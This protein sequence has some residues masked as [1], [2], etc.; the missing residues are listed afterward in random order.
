MLILNVLK[1][2]CIDKFT[3]PAK[4]AKRGQKINALVFYLDQPFLTKV[5]YIMELGY[6]M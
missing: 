4:R 3:E 5:S 2:T 1:N 6:M